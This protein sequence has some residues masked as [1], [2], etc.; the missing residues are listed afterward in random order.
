MKK[1]DIFSKNKLMI[2]RVTSFLSVSWARQ[3]TCHWNN[4]FKLSFETVQMITRKISN[5][6]IFKLKIKTYDWSEAHRM[7]SLHVCPLQVCSLHVCPMNSILLS[8]YQFNMGEIYTVLPNISCT[9]LKNHSQ[10]FLWMNLKPT[11]N[12]R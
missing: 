6:I 2:K 9:S 11:L 4:Q 10:E 3:G 1:L 12:F 5:G 8:S 7:V